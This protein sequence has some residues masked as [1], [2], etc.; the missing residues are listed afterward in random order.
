[1]KLPVE[2]MSHLCELGLITTHYSNMS[3]R[4]VDDFILHLGSDRYATDHEI[5]HSDTS[6]TP[7]NN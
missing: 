1:M 2:K 3:G 6:I 5:M 7:K 4:T